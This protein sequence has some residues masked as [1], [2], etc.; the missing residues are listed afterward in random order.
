MP[1]WNPPSSLL[2]PGLDPPTRL[3]ASVLDQT[4]TRQRFSP[5][6]EVEYY[7][8]IK[9]NEIVPF[10]K[11]WMDLEDIMLSEISHTRERQILYY[12]IYMWNLRNKTHEQT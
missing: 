7:S 11:I 2:V 1:F 5:T 3:L 12:F 9:K 6:Y 8:A 4:T 10:S